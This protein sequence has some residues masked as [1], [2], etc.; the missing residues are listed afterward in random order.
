VIFVR[1]VRYFLDATTDSLTPGKAAKWEAFLAANAA[2]LWR[3]QDVEGKFPL[4][5][6]GGAPMHFASGNVQEQVAAIDAFC[7]AASPSSPENDPRQKVSS[8]DPTACS[9]HG[10][11]RN[12]RCVCHTRFVVSSQPI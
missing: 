1:Y 8:G 12:G 5:W 3:S 2:S 10:S 4:W 9:G 6:G 11:N 7:A